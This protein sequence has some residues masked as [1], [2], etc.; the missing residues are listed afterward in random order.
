M[1]SIDELLTIN[2][3]AEYLKL[4]TKTVRRLIKNKNLMASLVGRQWRI[5]YKD[6]MNYLNN[7]SNR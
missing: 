1:Q 5:K 3:T 7:T 4:S 6:I 2:Q